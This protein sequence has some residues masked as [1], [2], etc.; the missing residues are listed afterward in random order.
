MSETKPDCKCLVSDLYNPQI[1]PEGWV[2]LR[3]TPNTDPADGFVGIKMLGTGPDP[4]VRI[5]KLKKELA[6]YKDH[7][8][9]QMN[10]LRLHSDVVEQQRKTYKVRGVD[11]N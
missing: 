9:P 3:R 6:E 2:M 11:D 10:Q 7:F 8:E 5:F 1:L 4:L